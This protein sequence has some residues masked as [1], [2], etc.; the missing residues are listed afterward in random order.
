[1][2]ITIDSN[3]P[4]LP[5]RIVKFTPND[6]PKEWCPQFNNCNA[7]STDY[8]TCPTLAACHF[9]YN[10]PISMSDN[11]AYYNMISFQ[12][13][14]INFIYIDSSDKHA[15]SIST[16]NR[17]ISNLKIAKLE[18]VIC[19]IAV[20]DNATAVKLQKENYTLDEDVRT[21]DYIVVI[22]HLDNKRIAEFIAHI[23]TM[24]CF[25]RA[26]LTENEMVHIIYM[27]LKRGDNKYKIPENAPP[28]T[29]TITAQNQPTIINLYSL[30]DATNSGY[31]ETNN[32]LV[33]T[34]A[35]SPERQAANKNTDNA[36]KN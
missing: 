8:K 3:V 36:A 18:T 13:R 27:M 7:I 22:G 4:G 6:N 14:M 23:V 21:S 29:T 17:I 1:M 28:T 35:P 9:Y 15:S 33:C 30:L 31:R 19:F 32:C 26:R 11:I 2:L 20:A 16:R 24:H 25:K 10:T 5:Q 12:P 34:A